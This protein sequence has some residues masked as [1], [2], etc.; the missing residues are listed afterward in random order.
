MK[1]GVIG[2]GSI[3]KRHARNAL[4]LG[5][6]V[7]GFDVKPDASWEDAPV[8]DREEDLWSW[9]PEAVIVCTPPNLH[10]RYASHA[11]LGG[12]CHVLIEKPITANLVEAELLVAQA[13]MHERVL[14]VGYQLR[15]QL[16]DVLEIGWRKNVSWESGQD[17]DRWPSRYEKDG[18]LEFSHE[19]DAAVYVNGWA[20]S[21]AAK[22]GRFKTWEITLEHLGCTSTILL[23][24]QSTAY[25]RYAMVDGHE[26]WTFDPERNEQAYK[27]ELQEFIDVCS[28]KSEM[29]PMLCSGPE[30]VHVMRIIAASRTSAHEGRV[31]TV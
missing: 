25:S 17:M 13:T 23:N 18:L 24:P 29:G 12:N 31:V 8:V 6:E 4:S 16:D 3:G 21:V 20:K 27:D 7:C 19:I 2:V 9:E 11:L 30:A 28:G 14:A 15:W 22:H 26:V 5:H 10:Y 1:L